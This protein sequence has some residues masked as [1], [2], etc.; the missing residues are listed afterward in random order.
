MNNLTMEY[1][2]KLHPAI[3]AGFFFPLLFALALWIRFYFLYDVAVLNRLSDTLKNI[4]KQGSFSEGCSR[5]NIEIL[6]AGMNSQT[7]PSFREAWDRLRRDMDTQYQGGFIPE[8]GAYFDLESLI[9]VPGGRKS[10]SSLWAGFGILAL[11]SLISPI[12]SYFF[13]RRML[14][15]TAFVLGFWCLFNLCIGH[16]VFV[17]ADQKAFQ[18]AI[19]DYN[20]FIKLFNRVMPV[21]GTLT[22]AA[23]LLEATERNQEAFRSSADKVVAKFDTFSSEVVLPAL[24]ES[25]ALLIDGTLVPAVE[26]IEVS[27]KNAMDSFSER[28]EEEM[29]TMTGAFADKLAGTL[30]LRLRSLSKTLGKVE[31]GLGAVNTQLEN[32][33]TGMDAVVNEQKLTVQQISDILLKTRDIQLA[34]NQKQDLFN[35]RLGALGENVNRMEATL[36]R[37]TMES[38]QL[39]QVLGAAQENLSINV[40]NL[41]EQYGNLNRLI[42]DMMRNITDRMNDAMTSAGREIGKGIQGAT[43]DN[44]QAITELTEQ[45]TK[46]H[47]DY[48]TY[49]SRLEDNTKQILDDM[50]FHVQNITAK[51]AEEISSMFKDI[52]E[53]NTQVLDQYKDSTANLLKSFDEQA[54]SIGLYAKE[55]SYDITELSANMKGSVAM[56]SK[57]IQEGINLSIGEFDS[58]LAELSIR[59]ANTV[60]SIADAV[61]NIPTAI[62]GRK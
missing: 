4:I 12:L 32:N 60:E 40:E 21:A 23:L 57:Q 44:A 18:Q 29:K 13:V 5:Q 27:L 6:E 3:W 25:M 11:L 52:L 59:I 49:F 26:R 20:C 42:T 30:E 15:Q 36:G 43:A 24:K 28:Q 31:A 39:S 8:A 33:L 58:G 38:G 10:I 16:A 51:M 61:E 47:D 17:L 48:D 14:S 22:G 37:F 53:Q 50:D 34:G 2:S 56:F 46:L 45:A 54:R 7:P 9:L 62:S 41:Q 35:D 19:N 1:I 55:M